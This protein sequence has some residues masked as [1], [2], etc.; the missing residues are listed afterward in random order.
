MSAWTLILLAY[1]DGCNS[2]GAG[3]RAPSRLPFLG[4]KPRSCP[5]GSVLI[6]LQL[7]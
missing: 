5:F 7:S 4:S 2:A 3:A 1:P 6:F